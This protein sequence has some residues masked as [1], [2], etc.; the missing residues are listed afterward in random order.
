[1]AKDTEPRPLGS[2]MLHGSLTVA[3][4]LAFLASW[5]FIRFLSQVSILR[6]FQIPFFGDRKR[7]EASQSG[8]RD[9]LP[10][11]SVGRRG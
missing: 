9:M 5:G 4:Q 6:I 7:R 3:A 11:V 2:G 10:L 1:M 8:R